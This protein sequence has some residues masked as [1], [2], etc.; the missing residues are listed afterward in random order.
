MCVCWVKIN[1]Q[2]LSEFRKM[3]EKKNQSIVLI[4]NHSSITDTLICQLCFSVQSITRVKMLVSGRISKMPFIGRII[5]GCGHLSIPFVK[6]LEVDQKKINNVM[7]DFEEHLI[8]KGFV[9]WFPEGKINPTPSTLL[10]FRARAF[11]LAAR[12]DVEIWSLVL[13]GPSKLWPV[14]AALGGYPAEIDGKI[15]QICESSKELLKWSEKK[16]ERDHEVF[17]ANYC[18]KSMKDDLKDLTSGSTLENAKSPL[19]VGDSLIVLQKKKP[20][21]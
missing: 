14:A 18:Q 3:T 7:A 9:C 17:L 13:S 5:T 10:Q 2:G 20:P 15:H 16:T 12:N 6:G 8:K 19:L 4:C 11:G 21:R 1:I